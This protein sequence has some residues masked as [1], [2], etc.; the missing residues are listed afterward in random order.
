MMKQKHSPQR[1]LTSHLPRTLGLSGM[2]SCFIRDTEKSK[3]EKNKALNVGFV[4]V[5]LIRYLLG[6]GVVS[7]RRGL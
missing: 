7:A 6:M 4:A 1:H 3:A 2:A 5:V